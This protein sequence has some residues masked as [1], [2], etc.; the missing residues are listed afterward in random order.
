MLDRVAD[1]LHTQDI[2]VLSTHDGLRPHCSLMAYL[3]SEDC[4][5]IYMVTGADTRKY[6]NMLQNDQVSLLV[7]DRCQSPDRSQGRALTVGGRF[8]LLADAEQAEQVKQDFAARF[9]HLLE[10]LE[11]EDTRLVRIRVHSFLLLDGPTQSQYM[12]VD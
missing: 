6:K 1:L 12:T 7:D 8:Q 11:Q 3:A 9:P 2:C 5:E 4:R 10:L